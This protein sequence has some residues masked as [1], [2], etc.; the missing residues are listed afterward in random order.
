M[1]LWYFTMIFSGMSLISSSII[2]FLHI[3]YKNI[4]DFDVAKYSFVLQ[5]IDFLLSLASL[6]PFP[7]FGS[8]I[9]CQL[10]G[11]LELALNVAL[12]LWTTIISTALYYEIYLKKGRNR[13]P[14]VK[15]LITIVIFCTIIGTISLCFGLYSEEGPWCTI[16]SAGYLGFVMMFG[17]FYIPLW[18]TIL[19]NL[20]AFT[21]L[22]QKLKND[23]GSSENGLELISTIKYCPFVLIITFAPI[24]IVRLYEKLNGNFSKN[25][26]VLNIATCIVRTH[27]LLNSLTYGINPEVKKVIFNKKKKNLIG[28]G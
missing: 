3:K 5:F 18:M 13:F 2:L 24:S 22:V 10:Q 19:W 27:G 1:E 21:K 25:N 23:F 20:Y 14:F 17:I 11:F 6:I 4:R 12:M 8:L 15:S 16:N 26:L 28:L 9:F 7:L